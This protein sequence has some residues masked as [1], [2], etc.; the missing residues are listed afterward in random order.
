MLGNKLELE[1]S[2]LFFFNFSF[3]FHQF[4]QTC[5]LSP[6]LLHILCPLI[7][8]LSDK[9]IGRT[10]Q[11]ENAKSTNISRTPARV[12]NPHEQIKLSLSLCLPL[13]DVSLV[14]TPLDIYHTVSAIFK[15]DFLILSTKQQNSASL[16]HCPFSMKAFILLS[17]VSCPYILCLYK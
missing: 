14:D 5:Y 9:F 3:W 10:L 17:A 1:L 13:S 2:L 7:V 6:L 12:T 4:Q 15:K 16:D 11:D 8:Q